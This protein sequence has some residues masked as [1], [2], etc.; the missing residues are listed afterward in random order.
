MPMVWRVLIMLNQ[1]KTL[2]VPDL[3]IEDLLIAYRLRSLGNSH[4]LLFSTS[5]NPS[6]SKHQRMRKVGNGNFS[7]LDGT[8]LSKVIAFR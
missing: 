6:S 2:H 5:S 1:I 4:F 7:L 3:C 8:P